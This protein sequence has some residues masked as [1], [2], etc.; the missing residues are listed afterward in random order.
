M[1]YLIFLLL[2][3]RIIIII[4]IIIFTSIDLT[5]FITK[6]IMNY[7]EFKTSLVYNKKFITDQPEP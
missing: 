4:I 6:F 2:I 5:I 1:K 7:R 3:I